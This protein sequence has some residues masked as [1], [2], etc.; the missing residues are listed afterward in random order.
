MKYNSDVDAVLQATPR[1]LPS[2]IDGPVRVPLM[3]SVITG[4]FASVFAGS[5]AL[6]F[7]VAIGRSFAIAGVTFSTVSLI[8]WL[9]IRGRWQWIIEEILLADLNHDGVVG[10]PEPAP[11]ARPT[12]IDV[13]RDNGRTINHHYIDGD[14]RM[15]I[16]AE[17]LLA[18]TPFSEANWTPQ[19]VLFSQSEFYKLQRDWI[20][21][22]RARWRGRT[23]TDGVEL[24]D[25]GW[26]VVE[27]IAAGRDVDAETPPPP[28]GPGSGWHAIPPSRQ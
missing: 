10:E 14:D 8:A 27:A 22:G 4:V 6:F 28:Q 24:T 20:A 26:A 9:S 2:G 11:P 25:D 17:G 23:A 19:S 1:P 18:G 5:V 15:R 16:L 3:Q 7:E 12:R 21:K 13:I